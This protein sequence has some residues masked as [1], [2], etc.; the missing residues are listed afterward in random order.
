MTIEAASKWFYLIHDSENKSLFDELQEIEGTD[1]RIA[2]AKS[3]GYEFTLEEF[4]QASKEAW[5]TAVGELSDEQLE[6]VAGGFSIPGVFPPS[7]NPPFAAMPAYAVPASYGAWQ[8]L[9]RA[10]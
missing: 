2:F 8:A 9:K 10:Q 4:T 5:D 3:K 7:S 1:A 6:G